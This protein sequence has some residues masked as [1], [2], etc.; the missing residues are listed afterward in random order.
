M[1][2]D[3]HIYILKSQTAIRKTNRVAVDVLCILVTFEI[4]NHKIVVGKGEGVEWW[5]FRIFH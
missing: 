3:L 4:V 5:I 1:I 2:E